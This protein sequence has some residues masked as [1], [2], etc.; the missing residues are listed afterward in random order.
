ML[1]S[2]AVLW[3]GALVAVATAS[4]AV[5]EPVRLAAAAPAIDVG[6]LLTARGGMMVAGVDFD[7]GARVR[8]LWDGALVAES[9]LTSNPDGTFSRSTVLSDVPGVTPLDGSLGPLV[10]D[11]VFNLSWLRSMAGVKIEDQ[12]GASFALS[13]FTPGRIASAVINT[14]PERDVQQLVDVRIALNNFPQLK[15]ELLEAAAALRVA[16]LT[17]DALRTQARD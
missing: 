7:F 14:A 2:A 12:R 16:D 4:V 6:V 13:A 9:T 15:S 11:G 17:P 5:A 8:V 10:K 3:F 1:R